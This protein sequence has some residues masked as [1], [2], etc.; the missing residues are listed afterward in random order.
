MIVSELMEILRHC[1][2]NAVVEMA[3]DGHSTEA[4]TW[5]EGESVEI[6]CVWPLATT[7]RNNA[8]TI[9]LDR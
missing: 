2:C 5:L 7:D 6:E 9:L 1:N 4:G 8:E 3:G